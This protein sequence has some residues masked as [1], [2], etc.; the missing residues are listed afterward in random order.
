[1]LFKKVMALYIRLSIE[2]GD[3]K[4]NT[5]KT[6]SNSVTNQRK[7]LMDYI[8][9]HPEPVYYTHLDV[10]KRQAFIGT[11]PVN[12]HSCMKSAASLFRYET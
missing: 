11:T 4:K 1:M 6:E 8:Q 10:Y 2:D 7:L 5:D 9:S 12:G 3:L